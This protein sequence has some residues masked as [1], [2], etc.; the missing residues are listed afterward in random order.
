L[1]PKKRKE[2]KKM[3]KAIAAITV[4]LILVGG[5]VAANADLLKNGNFD[6]NVGLTGTQWGVFSSIGNNNEWKIQSGPGIEVQRNTVVKAQTGNQYVELD[7][8]PAPGNSRMVQSVSLTSGWYELDFFYQPRTGNKD[9]NGISYGIAD[10][11]S[12]NDLF[13]WNVDA[14]TKTWTGWQEV[15]QAFY[16][17]ADKNYNVFFSAI[18]DF[19][20][21]G[22][23]TLG[24]FIDSVTLEA[25]PVPEPATM[26]L[27]G[28]GLVGL[29]GVRLRRK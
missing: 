13:S 26:L 3:R 2:R 23:N 1:Q 24:G 17:A 28:A 15:S 9:D 20:Y 14:T 19:G 4:G 6:D 5:V 18:G 8:N 10:L 21:N 27:L 25:A 29:A 12:N 16:I 11:D 22:G 7:S